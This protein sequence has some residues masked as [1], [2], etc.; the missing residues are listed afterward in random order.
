MFSM[1]FP[2]SV[3]YTVRLL[4]YCS[5]LKEN[6]HMSMEFILTKIV[7]YYFA[8][9]IIPIFSQEYWSIFIPVHELLHQLESSRFHEFNEFTIQYP[10]HF[11]LILL[12]YLPETKLS[13]EYRLIC[14]TKNCAISF[15]AIRNSIIYCEEIWSYSP[16][17]MNCSVN[18]CTVQLMGSK[19][20]GYSLP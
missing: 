17:Y 13:C 11:T 14:L 4:Y 8:Q 20:V 10:I 1:R 5:H 9:K 18:E 16:R 15:C 7:P 2:Y 19:K 3:L 6:C 12:L